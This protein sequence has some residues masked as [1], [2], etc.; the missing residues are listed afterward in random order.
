MVLEHL[1]KITQEVSEVK[2]DVFEI[3]S[4]VIDL[5]TGQTSM[6]EQIAELLEFKIEASQKFDQIIDDL[7]Y[8]KHKEAQNEADIFKLKRQSAR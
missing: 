2:S 8:L 1:A 7:D 5:K 6:R 3:K 4:D